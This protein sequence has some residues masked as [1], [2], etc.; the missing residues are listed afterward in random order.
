[1]GLEDKSIVCNEPSCELFD[2]GVRRECGTCSSRLIPLDTDT[3]IE[4]VG[5]DAETYTNAKGGQQSKSP[6]A[7]HLVD[8]NFMAQMALMHKAGTIKT[9]AINCICDY[10]ISGVDTD[11][12]L[13][14]CALCPDCVKAIFYI[15]EV[16]QYGATE[17]NNGKGYPI[18]NWRLINREDHLNH[19]LIHLFAALAGD[20][21]DDHIGH[22]LCRLHMALSTRETEGFHYCKPADILMQDVND[23]VIEKKVPEGHYSI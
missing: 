4:G 14:I 9:K 21:Q 13:A 22:A 15:G 16:L 10:M 7:L 3:K 1:M 12:F 17:G 5:S 18:G 11:L 20:N 2:S 6:A 19:A 23:Y 8:P